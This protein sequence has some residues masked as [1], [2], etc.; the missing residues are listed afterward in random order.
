MDII[1][2]DSSQ[3]LVN[4]QQPQVAQLQQYQQIYVNQPNPGAI[5]GNN[6]KLR[7][8]PNLSEQQWAIQCC[9]VHE[10]KIQAEFTSYTDK[11]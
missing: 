1:W 8:R 11:L 10:T 4:S 7:R 2:T 3:Q 6:D 9:T 5:I